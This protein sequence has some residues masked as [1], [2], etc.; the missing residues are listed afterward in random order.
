MLLLLLLAMC[1][2]A[3]GGIGSSSNSNRRNYIG[4]THLNRTS[5]GHESHTDRIL[6]DHTP[7]EERPVVARLFEGLEQ[8]HQQQQYQGYQQ[9][10]S[11]GGGFIGLQWQFK[12]QKR[13]L[14]RVTL[15]WTCYKSFDSKS[16]LNTTVQNEVLWHELN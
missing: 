7:L 8:Q 13:D 6:N 3:C 5:T 4:H 10:V 9:S 12:K 16:G 15:K 11:S 2:P 14:R 1:R